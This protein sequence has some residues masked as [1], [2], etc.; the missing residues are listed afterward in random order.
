[1]YC[2][3]LTSVTIPS[4][5]T[6]IGASAFAR[7]TSLTSVK[8]EGTIAS[9]KFH[10]DA[11]GQSDTPYVYI[12]DLRDKYLATGGGIGTYTR[13]S[14]GTTWTKQGGGV[15]PGGTYI[16]TGSGTSFT[17]TNGG[18][19]VGTA[20]KPIQDVINAI[21]THAAGKDLTIQFGNGTTTLDIG[22]AGAYFNNSGGTWGAVTLTGK[23]T[24]TSSKQ[25]SGGTIYIG[26]S[27][28]VTSAADI[29]NTPSGKNGG[30]AFCNNST[31]AVTISGG[32][33][34][35]TY[36][37]VSNTGG[38]T[39][40]ITGG[41][42]STASGFPLIN[43]SGTVNITGG[44]VST[45]S[46]YS[47]VCYP[48]C[49]ITVSGTAKVTSAS[50]NPTILIDHPD[51]TNGNVAGRLEIKGGTV[52]NTGT[53]KAVYSYGTVSI[54]GGTVSATSGIAV[55]NSGGKA[56]TISGGKV[57]AT[58]GLG[59]IIGECAATISGG[60]VENTGS[61]KAVYSYGTVSITGGTVS[62]TSGIAVDN[63]GALAISGGT[64]SATTGV[65]VRS[66]YNYKLTVSG[67]ANITSARTNTDEG[68]IFLPKL[69]D[70]NTS[71]L[72]ITGGRVENTSTTSGNAIRHD[73]K[74]T[75]S[76]TGGT[77]SKAGDG[78]YAVYK[79]GTGTVTIG[80]G[81]NIVGN[82]YGCN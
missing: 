80:V 60:T 14:G 7:C 16:I 73:S 36:A 15:A 50:A 19:I 17:A 62:A 56:F 33:I 38:G 41:N 2:Y 4:S 75:V 49:T 68:T 74:G 45:T 35:G 8:F 20:N 23:I 64:V 18:V 25:S 52:E 10:N 31:V 12:G 65:A 61:G 66:Y 72:E 43:Y 1:M 51:Y 82:R 30:T 57:S 22:E 28:S 47:V 26:D 69:D 27:V 79:G 71:Q 44:T 48:T 32:T 5:V 37:A 53:G 29:T 78:N 67:T 77:V 76:I 40:S 21:R 13:Q 3:G 6:S 34:T 59:V 11:F 46:G 42:V 24:S 70:V 55:D 81:A 9:N 58:S 63:W 54:T 39:L